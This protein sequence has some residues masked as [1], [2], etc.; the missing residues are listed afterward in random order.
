MNDKNLFSIGELA[1]AVGIT[2]K[3]ML[4]YEAKD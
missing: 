4:G 3:A 1:K 2:K